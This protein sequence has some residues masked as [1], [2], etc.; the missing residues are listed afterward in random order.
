MNLLGLKMGWVEKVVAVIVLSAL[1]MGAFPASFA[2]AFEG[3]I[4]AGCTEVE[5]NNYNPDANTDDGSCAYTSAEVVYGCT[6]PLATNFDVLATS[7]DESCEYPYEADMQTI[8]VCKYDAYKYIEETEN[9]LPIAGWT[10]FVLNTLSEIE[11]SGDEVYEVVTGANGCVDV[12]VDRNN[13]PWYVI[14]DIQ[15]G[16]YQDDVDVTG[17]FSTRTEGDDLCVFFDYELSKVDASRSSE[18]EY[19]CDFYNE[20]NREE[21][22]GYK[23]SDVNNDGIKDESE[24]GVEGWTITATDVSENEYTAVSADTDANGFYSMM[25]PSNGSW[26]ITEEARSGWIQTAVF[27]NG[28]KLTD[29]TEEGGTTTECSLYLGSKYTKVAISD[30]IVALEL[31]NRCDFLNY[32][33]PR[34]SGGGSSGTK[35]KDRSTPTPQVLG[36]STTAPACG[37]YLNDY[38]R[39]GKEAS[40]T[41]VTKL[42]IFLNAVGIKLEVTG[43]FDA[44]TDAAVRKFQGDHKAEVLTPWYLAKL[45]PHENPTGWVYQ[46]TRWK[47]NN[48]VCPGSEAYPVLN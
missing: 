48:I 38:M 32:Q 31:Y 43:M 15:E 28:M 7:D 44:A 24:G 13:G 42:Q 21:V 17:G 22:S 12:E 4:V 14:E 36:A 16:W 6:D 33:E 1:V 8:T 23:W 46:L 19:R 37:M 41:E 25:L 35:V 47:I 18:Y 9:P 20:D 27:E 39:Q 10:M 40:S 2:Q 30:E 45:V 29:E 26:I 11:S 5:A 3:G 34:R